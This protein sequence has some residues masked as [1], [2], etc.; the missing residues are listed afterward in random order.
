VLAYDPSN[1]PAKLINVALLFKD[2][3]WEEGLAI[4]E[5]VLSEK[6]DEAD[7]YSLIASYHIKKE[8]L[9]K[10]TIVLEE[11]VSKV[12][13]TSALLLRLSRIYVTDNKPKKAEAI[14]KAMVDADPDA[15]P[16]RLLSAKFYANEKRVDEGEA[17][18]REGVA[19]NP[20]DDDRKYSLVRFLKESRD[21][22]SA[23]AA[24]KVFIESDSGN[25]GLRLALGELYLMDDQ[26]AAATTVYS[27]IVELDGSGP[28]G[29]KAKNVLARIRLQQND[30]AGALVLLN[31]V[32]DDNPKDNDALMIRARISLNDQDPL[33]AIADLRSVLRDLPESS[34][35]L[36]LL[37]GAHLMNKELELARDFMSKAVDAAPTDLSLRLAYIN[38]L[39]AGK[40]IGPTA[41]AIDQGLKFIP[42][43]FELLEKKARLEVARKDIVALRAVLDELLEEHPDKAL[44]HFLLAQMLAGEKKF[45]ESIAEYEKTL[46]IEPNGLEPL[47]GIA[48]GY[49]A[50]KQGG[51]AI[52][53]MDEVIEDNPKNGFAFY[54]RGTVKFSE[55]D[56]DGGTDDLMVAIEIVPEWNRPYTTL[57]L[58]KNSSG[59]SEGAL[60]VLRSGLDKVANRTSILMPIAAV[61][62]GA[63]D[64]GGAIE[65]Y[66]EVLTIEPENKVA[67]N[68]L[69]ALLVDHRSDQ[70]SLDRALD[71]SQQFAKH[72]NPSMKDTYGWVSFR[73]GDY[74]EALTAL[75]SV[76]AKAPNNAL[77][78]YHIGMVQHKSGMGLEAKS[79]L[80]KALELND[81]FRG[82]DEARNVLADL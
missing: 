1:T 23:G 10:A 6:P 37:A 60:V 45:E 19:R 36:H 77:F 76:V 67:A 38:L 16:P 33:S 44:G 64:I 20:D 80:S 12:D 25:F 43:S 28:D 3:Q 66:D 5:S 11:G 14:F 72:P 21:L 59:D 35:V 26:Q 62:D 54:V 55:K 18:L 69:A 68:N 71:L 57:A 13:N 27:E 79:S 52:A 48:K 73:R 74:P 17:V 78:L 50:Q 41:D 30:M 51:K 4:A 32:L 31:E 8:N 7:A 75:E 47:A 63:S 49:I 15:M 53:R 42:G 56:I 2:E 40:K 22:A 58:V 82:A 39:A 81:K 46:A 24:L 29:L 61:Q 70:A 65:T 9:D 34:Q